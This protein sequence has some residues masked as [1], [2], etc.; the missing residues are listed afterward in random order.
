M[1]ALWELAPPVFLGTML[2]IIAV[3]LLMGKH[4]KLLRGPRRLAAWMYGGQ[5]SGRRGCTCAGC[6]GGGMWKDKS[7]WKKKMMGHAMMMGHMGGGGGCPMM[8]A[9]AMKPTVDKQV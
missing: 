1:S 6:G 4:R 8:K 5:C 7:M 9:M 3:M 2:A